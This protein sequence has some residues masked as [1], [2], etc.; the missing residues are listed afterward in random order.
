M[1][2]D[3]MDPED[4]HT[5]AELNVGTT[6]GR[7]YRCTRGNCGDVIGH[8]VNQDAHNQSKHMIVRGA[9]RVLDA[10]SKGISGETP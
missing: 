3:M 4:L 2:A 7:N 9:D 1:S 10:V 5:D 6:G 8:P